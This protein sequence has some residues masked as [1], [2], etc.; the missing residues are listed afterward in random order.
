MGILAPNEGATRTTESRR[1]LRFRERE[2]EAAVSHV[3][4]AQWF[5]EERDPEFAARLLDAA[6]KEFP[7]AKSDPFF[8]SV[9]IA[10][11]LDLGQFDA[12]QASFRRWPE[13]DRGHAYWKWRAII[14]DDALG[15]Y[16]EALAAYDQALALWPGP[17]DWRLRHRQA[18]CLARLRRPEESAA[19]IDRIGRLA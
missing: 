4:V 14:L 17:A 18:G 1:Y 7:S 3:A 15:Q 19:M 8:L 12:A 6:A 16:E 9:S 13:N 11:H 5:Q 2:P 10:T